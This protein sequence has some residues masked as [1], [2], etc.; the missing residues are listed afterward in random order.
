LPERTSPRVPLSAT[1]TCKKSCVKKKKKKKALRGARPVLIWGGRMVEKSSV[2]LKRKKR[3]R[4][5]ERER[6]ERELN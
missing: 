1:W 6:N 3:E 2:V 4:E 5:R